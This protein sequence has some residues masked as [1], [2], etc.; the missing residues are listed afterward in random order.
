MGSGEGKM[1]AIHTTTS[2]EVERL[3]PIDIVRA[4]GVSLHAFLTPDNEFAG[5]EQIE[6][7]KK[8]QRKRMIASVQSAE[9][10]QRRSVTSTQPMSRDRELLQIE[11]IRSCY[12]SQTAGVVRPRSPNRL[13]KDSGEVASSRNISAAQHVP[14]VRPAEASRMVGMVGSDLVDPSQLKPL[15]PLTMRSALA[16]RNPLSRL[17]SANGNMLPSPYPV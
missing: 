10:S 1:Y 16:A 4:E 14:S 8:E 9:Q 12:A 6:E 2:D 3:F 5:E 17:P 11:A 15:I 7:V 13:A